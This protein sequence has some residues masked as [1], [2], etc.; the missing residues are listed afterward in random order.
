[1]KI[2]EAI[3]KLFKLVKDEPVLVVNLAALSLVAFALYVV[4][5]AIQN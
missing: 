2:V 1:M 4:L 5:Q 3:E